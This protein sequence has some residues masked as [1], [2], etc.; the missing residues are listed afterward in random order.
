VAM[1]P[2]GSAADKPVEA[3]TVVPAL[4]LSLPPT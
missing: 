3:A 1:N 4:L 2:P